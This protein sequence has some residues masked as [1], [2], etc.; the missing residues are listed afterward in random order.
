MLKGVVYNEKLYI[1][2]DEN[3]EVFNP[4][5]NT[6]SIWPKPAIMYVKRFPVSY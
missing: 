4:K 3:P 6:W 5:T 2:D 1:L